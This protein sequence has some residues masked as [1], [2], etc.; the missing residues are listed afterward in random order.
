MTST[1]IILPIFILLCVLYGVARSYNNT[2]EVLPAHAGDDEDSHGHSPCECTVKREK[3]RIIQLPNGLYANT[4]SFHRVAVVGTCM[5]K[6]GIMSGDEWLAEKIK[7]KKLKERLKSDDVLLIYLKDKNEYKLRRLRKVL[8]A[9][10]FATYYYKPDGTEHDS[11]NHHSSES[12]LGVV[13]YKL[14]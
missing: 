4:K 8:P 13:R 1:I 12:I 3:S 10:Q 7:S 5:E 6:I 2:D 9:G 11:R 14:G